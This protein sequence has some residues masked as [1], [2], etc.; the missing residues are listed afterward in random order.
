MERAFQVADLPGRVGLVTFDVPGQKVNTFS[1]PVLEEMT[2]LLDRLEQKTDWQGLLFRSGKAGQFIA[3][4]D[5]RELAALADG[6]PDGVEKFLEVGHRL[7]NRWANLPFP[8]VALIDGTTLGGGT[9]FS[10]ALD[11]RLAA[12]TPT[13][14][15][16]LPE[17]KLGMIPG[18]G[19]TQRLPRV[20]GVAKAVEMICGGEP[21]SA[22]QAQSC[23]LV[24]AVIPPEKVIETSCR[25]IEEWRKGN[26]WQTLRQTRRKTVAIDS[27]EW[28]AATAACRKEIHGKSDAR[29]TARLAALESI[30]EG[31]GRKLSEGL[32]IERRVAAT[33][34]GSKGAAALIAEFFAGKRKP[35]AGK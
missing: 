16:G 17:T 34:I 19:G 8:T 13:L 30:R 2:G 4:A 33:V 31:I 23:G 22:E 11:H 26:A 9:E 29:S 12:D 28:D 1:Q 6:P 5:L 25:L 24:E 32:D 3:G 35:D 15:I 20:V 27:A 7:F 14:C 10:L 18:W 21:I